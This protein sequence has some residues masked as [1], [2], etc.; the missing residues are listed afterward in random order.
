MN[1]TRA[2]NLRN[3]DNN[4]NPSG[5]L[6][7]RILLLVLL[8]LAG[9]LLLAFY[10][11]EIVH[12]ADSTSLKTTVTAGNTT[13][14][15]EYLENSG[16]SEDWMNSDIAYSS[17]DKK[18]ATVTA[19]GTVKGISAGK[20][21]I[22]VKFES[23]VWSDKAEKFVV[24]TMKKYVNVTVLASDGSTDQRTFE[25]TIKNKK[26]TITGLN[27]QTANII[28]PKQISGFPVTAISNYA[29]SSNE[30][31]K[32]F[33]CLSNMET[34]GDQ[35]FI[36]C[37]NL[38]K[39]VLSNS[40]KTIGEAA[41]YDCSSLTSI[42]LSTGL[43]EIKAS[44]FE[45]CSSLKSL[46]IPK[47]VKTIG[48]SAFCA[49]EKLVTVEGGSGVTSIGYGAFSN[50]KKLQSI[51]FIRNVEEIGAYAFDSCE[52]LTSL[53]Y[54][55]ALESI[56]E[57]IFEGTQLTEIF[58]GNKADHIVI[59]PLGEVNI[60]L[61]KTKEWNVYGYSFQNIT[62]PYS[63]K[64]KKG[65]VTVDEKEHTITLKN[66]GAVVLSL[67]TEKGN[68][69]VNINSEEL[70]YYTKEEFE[71]EQKADEIIAE[72][73]T[74]SMSDLAKVKVLH[75]YICTHTNHYI[76]VPDKYV[77]TA[78][79]VLILGNGSCAG[80][81]AAYKMLLDK[82]GVENKNVIGLENIHGWNAVRIDGEWYHVDTSW[83]SLYDY[84]IYYDWFMK[85]DAEFYAR[86][87]KETDRLFNLAHKIEGTISTSTKYSSVDWYHWSE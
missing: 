40:I 78:Y 38:K 39:V 51:D 53:P 81:Q 41:F 31:L 6:R 33:T 15:Y 55:E 10:P 30:K 76:V 80:Y 83:D 17:S 19:S 74:D 20:A 16:I 65:N 56:S 26:V 72:L 29:F 14:L 86:S 5:C 25:Y 63:L 32:S 23:C 68:L 84:N 59:N 35:A 87:D 13:S 46:S 85:N 27:K 4:F 9:M 54:L 66:S 28:I 44:T 49:C 8:S 42:T 79:G 71:T 64:V 69:N 37:V 34:I 1:I 12:A 3:Q 36:D 61:T 48:E 82:A 58:V 60:V 2:D 70:Q 73:I 75:D 45:G 52:S 47:S 11:A 21:K 62:L 67:T 22:T 18:I 50:C 57:G 43:Q 77:A 24:K 7:Q